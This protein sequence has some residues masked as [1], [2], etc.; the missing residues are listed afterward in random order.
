[1]IKKSRDSDDEGDC[2]AADSFDEKGYPVYK[3][4]TKDDLRVVPHNKE[5]L[6]DWNGHANLEFCGRTY[7]V[8]WK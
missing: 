7:A 1:M 2:K 8:A 3:R 5:I 6:F 4:P